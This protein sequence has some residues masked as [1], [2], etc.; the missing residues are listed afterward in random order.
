MK[1]HT[2]YNVYVGAILKY[3]VFT[4]KILTNSSEIYIK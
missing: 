1:Y 4:V 3:Y 2:E